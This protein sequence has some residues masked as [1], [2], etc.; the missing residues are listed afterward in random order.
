[1]DRRRF[2]Q[3]A[4]GAN[5]LAHL[6]AE[7]LAQSVSGA[8]L[9]D[10]DAGIVRH[11]LPAVNDSRMLIKVSFSRPL[12]AAPALVLGNRRFIGRMNDSHGEFWQFHADGL[13]AGRTYTLQLR[14]SRNEALC[15]PWEL[16]TFPASGSNVD[17]FRL[18]IYTC[19]GGHDSLGFL[20][21]R[22]RN[23]MFRRALSFGPQAV[24]ANGDHVYWD[25][26]SPRGG[27]ILARS[28]Q[29]QKIAGDFN[30]SA[31]VL[32][33]DNETLLKSVVTPQIAP[34]YGTAFRST[35]MFFLQDDHDHFENDE[36]TDEMVTFPP[37]WFML[38]LARATQK[39]YYPEFLPD[40]NR[41]G[42][43]PW[44]SS[45]DRVNGLSESFGTL[46]YGNLAEVLLFDVRRTMT[47]AGP[48]SVFIDPVVESWLKARARAIDTRH[49]VHVPSSPLGWSAGKWGEWYPDVLG[50]DRRLTTAIPKPYWQ[51]GWLAQHDRIVR[52][53]T[54]MRERSP[55]IISGDLHALA[56]G[57]M[58]RSGTMD[59]S[60][61]PINIALAG[62]ISTGDNLWPSAF[63]GVGPGTPAHVDMAEELSPLEQ[64]GFTLVDFERDEI[65][66]QFFRWD[67][68]SQDPDEIDSLMPF[69][70]AVIPRGGS[71]PG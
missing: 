43:L 44:S 6:P 62:P 50:D 32:G 9:D 59:L 70:S 71:L 12:A 36:A 15:E 26:L 33:S 25:I 52:S 38:Q 27:A 66:L 14:S 34:V 13:D 49:L 20:P 63:R 42:Y 29:G 60:A 67:V 48:T 8:N 45:D 39:L 35:P 31:L 58:M 17:R 68:K 54:N 61:N 4:L 18:L 7:L 53:L 56:L 69:H 40:T 16:A 65:G 55:M 41:P 22:V 28:E 47:M 19:A 2:L 30:R 23:R 24:I 3:G 1:M 37:S 64:H 10:W 11:L 57:K 51:Q 5:I 21:A 46:R